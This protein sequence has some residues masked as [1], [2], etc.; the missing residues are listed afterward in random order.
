V[1]TPTPRPPGQIPTDARFVGLLEQAH[2]LLPQTVALRRAIHREPE[3]GLDLPRT[4]AVVLRALAGLDLR[5][6][7]GTGLSSVVAELAGARPGP[8]VLLRADMDALPL[9][10]RTDLPFRS[11]EPE[12]MHACGHDLHTAMLLA[13]ARLLAGRRDELAGRVVFAFQP[14]EEGQHGARLMLAEGLLDEPVALAF[15]AHVTSTLPAGVLACRPGPMMASSD[16]FRV[17][18]TGRGGHAAMPHEAIDPVPAAAAMVGALHTMLSRRLGGGEPAV[19]TVSELRAGT[20]TNII[21]DT[22]EL[23][24]TI[25]TLDEQ[26]RTLLRRELRRVCEHVGLAHE[27]TVRTTIEAGYPVT[28]NSA[29]VAERVLELGAELFGAGQVERMERPLLGAEDFAYVLGS[30]PGALAFLGACPPA[31]PVAEA[32]PNHSAR[33]V[34]DESVLPAGAALHAAVALDTLR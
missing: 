33:A 28:V 24:G 31:L 20:T 1:T 22:A 14:G 4:Q 17:L 9:T 16:T 3:L 7:T 19:L 23:A 27:C 13:A 8:T 21:P 34:F 25:R 11:T 10:E 6:R 26:T 5:V 2:G 30:A 32:A 15:A 12:V 29:R 18:V